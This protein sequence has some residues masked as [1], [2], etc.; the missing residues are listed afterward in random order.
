MRHDPTLE[1]IAELMNEMEAYHH[2]TVVIKIGGNSIAEDEHFLSK[3]ARQIKFLRQ[4]GVYVVLIHGGGPQ[5]DD[6]LRDAKVETVK[7]KDGRR[8]TSPKAMSIVHKTMNKINRDVADALI[9]AGCRKDKVV[10]AAKHPKLFVTAEPLDSKDKGVTNRSGKPKSV[11]HQEIKKLLEQ[12]KVVVLH[13]VGVGPD[14]KSVFN[15]NGDDYAMAVA[16]AIKAKRLILVTN[17]SGVLDKKRERIP[18]LDRDMAEELIKNGTITGGMVP[19]VES[20][21][22]VVKQGVGGVAIIDGFAPWAI[23]AEMLTHEGFGTL[24]RHKIG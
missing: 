3:I 22:W 21:L 4:N 18:T 24:V 9:A 17:V 13:S 6:A 2:R 12:N 20:A 7:G 8:I 11:A 15:I 14:G 16:I 23:L 5:I 19:K 1:Q 10:F